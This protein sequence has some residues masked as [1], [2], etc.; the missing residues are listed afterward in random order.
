MEYKAMDDSA[1][2]KGVTLEDPH[3]EDLS[4][5]VR[6]FIFS[7]I[8]IGFDDVWKHTCKSRSSVEFFFFFLIFFTELILSCSCKSRLSV[9]FFLWTPR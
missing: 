9:D 4:Q 6:G 2:K 3:T 7:R 5:E 1:I 8:V